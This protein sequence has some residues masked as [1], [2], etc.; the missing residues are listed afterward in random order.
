MSFIPNILINVIHDV[1]YSKSSSR[2][3]KRYFFIT[4]MV[5]EDYTALCNDKNGLS[6]NHI[7]LTRLWTHTLN[8]APH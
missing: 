5:L 8:V 7:Q 3:L 6:L 2:V 1:G 4:V